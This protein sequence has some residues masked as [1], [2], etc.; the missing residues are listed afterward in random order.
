MFGKCDT[1]DT[2]NGNKTLQLESLLIII[3]LIAGV[4][5]RLH[6]IKNQLHIK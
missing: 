6:V 3:L 5:S 1:Y 2:R 4:C